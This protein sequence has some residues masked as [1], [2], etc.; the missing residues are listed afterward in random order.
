MTYIFP[1]STCLF[2]KVIE[3]IEYKLGKVQL[4]LAETMIIILE[5]DM[6]VM[7]VREQ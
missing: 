2:R 4:N 1:V 5:N 7:A 6:L 3:I